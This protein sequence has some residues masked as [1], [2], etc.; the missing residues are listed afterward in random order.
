[1]TAQDEELFVHYVER[2]AEPWNSSLAAAWLD[3]ELRAWVLPRLPARR[4]LAA[5]NVGIGVGLWDDW[6]GHVLGTGG[7]LVSVDRDPSICRVFA[8]RQRR[9][10]HPHPAR[11][12]CGDIVDGVLG[13]L[14][15]DVITIVGST[16]READDPRVR[17][18]LHGALADGGC[19][20]SAEVGT[21][22]VPESTPGVEVRV[23]DEMWIRLE[24]AG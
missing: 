22:A 24:R 17:G 14:R 12:L 13:A 5:C 18:M 4:P 11:V 15:F 10:R 8:H 23:F 6:L 1:M 16:L 2:G 21:G 19:M 20:L 7:S 9:E 3:Y